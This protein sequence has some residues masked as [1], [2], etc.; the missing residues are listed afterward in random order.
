VNLIVFLEFAKLFRVYSE[1]MVYSN[2]IKQRISYW[3]GKGLKA[4]S[5]YKKLSGEG[6]SC[7][8]RGVRKF[9]V[10]YEATGSIRR[11]RGSGRPSKVTEEVEA[12]IEGQ[13]QAND[14]T[15]V[16]ELQRLLKRQRYH[17]SR[18]TI[19]RCRKRLG[20]SCRGTA[21][22]QLIREP[23]REKRLTWAKENEHSEFKDAIFTD[24][25]TVQMETHR[26]FCCRKKSQKPR[27]KPR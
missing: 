22:C 6:L 25:T 9:I 5:I 14:E 8:T 19:L 20:W 3:H 13:M 27:Y 24:E 21:Y 15:T 1:E 4:P 18:S 10:K 12:I 7:S 2:Y 16:A 17:L 26:R 23:N 11:K